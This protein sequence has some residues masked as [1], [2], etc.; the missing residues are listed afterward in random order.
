M[1]MGMIG[2][3]RMGGNMAQRLMSH[4]HQCLVY[5]IDPQTRDELAAMG[6]QAFDTLESLL[7]AMESPRVLWLMLPANVVDAVI[8]DLMA[9]L[10]SGDVVVDGGNSRWQDDLGRAQR[11]AS[12]GVAYMDVG[13]SG[14]V[15]GRERGYCLMVGG[16]KA[17]FERI[18]PLL[19]ALA[20]GASAAPPTPGRRL[21]GSAEQGYLHCGASGAGH[22]VKMVHNGIEYGIM[23]AYAEGFN[24]LHQAGRGAEGAD[25]SGQVPASDQPM[26]LE[27]PEH[28]TYDFDLAEVAEVW[29]RGSVIGSWLL[30]LT[31]QSLLE[32]P[33]L[34]RFQGRVSDS[35]EGRWAMGAA[36]DLGVPVPVLS[37]S[38]FSRFESRGAADF[39]MKTLSAMRNQFGGH[40]EHSTDDTQAEPEVG[41]Q[42]QAEAHEFLL[43]INP[44][45][46]MH[47][48]CSV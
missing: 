43:R 30:D 32:D 7:H 46:P 27:N 19:L 48:S 21:G 15:R 40:A 10:H 18:E 47:W 12:K 20:P 6:A 31:A 38:L 3:G 11:L 5:D 2:L 26:P 24:L 39:A 28:Y 23:A 13:T 35:G 36:I 44:N 17:G 25:Q 41:D 22:Y 29:R 8:D 1:Q 9:Q 4:G 33:G 34:Q 37:A 14:G 45:G 16:S 42:R